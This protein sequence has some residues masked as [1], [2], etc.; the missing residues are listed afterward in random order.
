L[1]NKHQQPVIGHS[2]VILPIV[3]SSNNYAMQLVHDGTAVHGSAFMALQQTAGRG[4]RTNTWHTGQSENL[5]ISVIIEPKL[6]KIH[7][8]F[9]LNMYVSVS[10][11][12]CLNK[13]KEGFCIKWPND[14]YY[15]D[16]KAAGILIENKLQGTQWNFAIVGIGINVNQTEF[17]IENANPISL[18]EM[19]GKTTDL[20]Q[21]AKN[22][23]SELEANWSI[24]LGNQKLFYEKY[25]NAL[26]KKNQI[27][28]L[29]QSSKIFETT[30]KQVL[31]N[32]QLIC[33]SNGEYEFNFGE[34]GWIVEKSK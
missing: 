18:M 31:E 9:L 23:C 17:T 11:L 30:V 29:K 33:G 27:V 20:Y 19:T 21:L 13:I 10:I 7:Q 34:V 12:Q 1:L 32:G 25:N 4:Q 3:D 22:I 15:N 5:A 24:F 16:R 28:K 2:L 8:Q 26:Y 14:I 6:L